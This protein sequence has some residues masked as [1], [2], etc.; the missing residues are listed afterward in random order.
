VHRPILL[1]CGVFGFTGFLTAQDHNSGKALFRSNCAFCHGVNALGGRGP[2]LLTA[3]V[4]QATS[5]ADLKTI[6][7]KG[8]AGTS[9]PAFDNL[10]GDDLDKLI[11]HIRS[12]ASSGVVSAPVTGDVN[13]GAQVYA[14][15][16]CAACHRTGNSGSDYGPDLTRIGGSRS[17][18]YIRQSVVDPSADIPPEYEGV[19]VVTAQDKKL[20]GVRVNEDT[21]SLQLRLQ[22]DQ[23]ALFKKS[24]LKSVSYEKKSLMPAYDKM[25]AKDLQDLIAYLDTWRGSVAAANDATKAKGIH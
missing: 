9:M 21:F 12:L 8:I 14:S 3:K 11:G 13:H 18:E 6:V 1:L 19:N 4:S 5:D 16:G 24:D 17:A 20:T 22:N 15:S 7:Q 2:S 10:E 25:A 23:F